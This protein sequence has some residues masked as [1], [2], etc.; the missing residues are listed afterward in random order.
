MRVHGV[1]VGMDYISKA[2]PQDSSK[3]ERARAADDKEN[4]CSQVKTETSKQLNGEDAKES[5]EPT[6]NDRVETSGRQL[7]DSNESEEI[8]CLGDHLVFVIGALN[9]QSALR[10]TCTYLATDTSHPDPSFRR[11]YWTAEGY[12]P[13]APMYKHWAT[14]SVR[15]RS[16][17]RSLLACPTHPTAW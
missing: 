5:T 6:E 11:W 4:N 8:L 14:R 16:C 3:Q 17:G 9:N 15:Y 12:C 7:S 13:C 1:V 10:G 2:N